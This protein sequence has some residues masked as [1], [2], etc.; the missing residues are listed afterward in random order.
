MATQKEMRQFRDEFMC[1]VSEME[2]T[3]FTFE[4]FTTD[5]PVFL[6]DSGDCVVVKPIAKKE[7]FD[8]E[9]AISEWEEKQIAATQRE[10]DKLDKAAARAEKAQ[11]KA[12]LEANKATT[13]AQKEAEDEEADQDDEVQA[14]DGELD[15]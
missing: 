1:A 10:Q 9:D 15:I 5:G 12:V 11:A 4:G 3:G 2:I 7:D 14:L 8:M 6:N 13:K